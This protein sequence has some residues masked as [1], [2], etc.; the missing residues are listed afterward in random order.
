[1]I[2]S[3]CF[4][5]CRLI[6][7]QR[8][9]RIAFRNGISVMRVGTIVRVGETYITIHDVTTIPRHR[10]STYQTSKEGWRRPRTYWLTLKLRRRRDK[11]LSRRIGGQWENFGSL[12]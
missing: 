9:K 12:D 2:P 4:Q 8:K 3:F 10:I 11:V 1:M 7:R 6:W 5:N